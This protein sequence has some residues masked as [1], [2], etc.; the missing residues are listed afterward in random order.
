P[1]P[2]SISQAS[3]PRAASS[4][5]ASSGRSWDG[6]PAGPTRIAGAVVRVRSAAVGEAYRVVLVVVR[7]RIVDQP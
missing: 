4:S 5:T 1:R 7:S 3:Y 2:N 6:T